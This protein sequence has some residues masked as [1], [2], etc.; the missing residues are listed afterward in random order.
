MSENTW[1]LEEGFADGEA[2]G[3]RKSSAGLRITW[4]YEKWGQS[5]LFPDGSIRFVARIGGTDLAAERLGRL[6]VQ[7]RGVAIAEGFP[8]ECVEFHDSSDLLGWADK[9]KSSVLQ[10]RVFAPGTGDGGPM[11]KRLASAVGGALR[12]GLDLVTADLRGVR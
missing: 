8:E 12:R 6:K 2:L 11:H 10:A 1:D 4:T 5:F 3:E 7:V 9:V